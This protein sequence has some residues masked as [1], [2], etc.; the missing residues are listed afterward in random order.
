MTAR[1]FNFSKFGLHNQIPPAKISL[2][3]NFHL[4]IQIP[5]GIIDTLPISGYFGHKLVLW[6]HRRARIFKFSKFGLHNRISPAKISLNAKFHLFIQIP[7]GIIDTLPIVGYCG[8]KLVL[9][10]HRRARNFKIEKLGLHSQI[11][12]VKISLNA[13]FRLFIQI[14]R[15]IIDILPI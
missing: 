15:G 5:R 11:F 1:I 10:R 4:F 7:R 2:N 14:P 8:P 3:T 9:W 13:N 12:P 6:C